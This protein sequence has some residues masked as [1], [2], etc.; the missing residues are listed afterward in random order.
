MGFGCGVERVLLN[1]EAQGLLPAAEKAVDAY[2]APLSAAARPVALGAAR[3]LRATG[4]RVIT[5]Y[6]AGSPRSHLR[7]ANA[8]GARWAV[9]L[10]DNE[11]AAGTAA[12]RDLGLRTGSKVTCLIKTRSLEWVG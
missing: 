7:K 1:L 6:S 2:V 9:I 12:V 11:L 4:L 8:L 3:D 10:G 5:G